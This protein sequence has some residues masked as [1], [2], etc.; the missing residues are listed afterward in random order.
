MYIKHHLIHFKYLI[1]LFVNYTS[2]K[3]GKKGLITEMVNA[4][5]SVYAI[6]TVTQP[7]GD[8]WGPLVPSTDAEVSPG[9]GCS[10]SASY[11]LESPPPVPQT[12]VKWNYL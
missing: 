7:V 4:Q 5:H 2:I 12:P 10:V 1:I 6:H 8:T 9:W 3:L 11:G